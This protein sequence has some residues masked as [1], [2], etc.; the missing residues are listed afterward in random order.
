[1]EDLKEN[2][3]MTAW[4]IAYKIALKRLLTHCDSDKMEEQPLKAK[5]IAD[6]V[7]PIYKETVKSLKT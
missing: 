2:D 6:L 1:M 5:I 3:L 7:L 4:D